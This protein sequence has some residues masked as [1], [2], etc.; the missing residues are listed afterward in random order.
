MVLNILFIPKS[1]IQNKIQNKE[2]MKRVHFVVSG[3]VQGVC[4]R[5][6]SAKKAKELGLSG[7]VRNL[8]DGSVEVVAEG[9]DKKVDAFLSFCKNNPSHSEVE[10][11]EIKEEKKIKESVLKNFDL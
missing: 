6:Y 10:R 8:G 4:Y 11:V 7:F 9:E 2:H 1:K 3:R 5:H